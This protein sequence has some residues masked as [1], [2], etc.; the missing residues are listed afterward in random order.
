MVLSGAGTHTASL[1]E[2]KATMGAMG[3]SIKKAV[4]HLPSDAHITPKH[5][6]MIQE[7]LQDPA[8]FYD[9]KAE[10]KASYSPASTTIIGVLK[11]MYDTF[12][13]N[14]EKETGTES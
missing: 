1:L 2:Q 10:A 5:M 6:R 3:R 4:Q 14:L 13:N 7:F 9:Q 11:D 8:E 12:V